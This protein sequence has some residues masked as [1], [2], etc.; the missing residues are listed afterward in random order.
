MSSPSVMNRLRT[1]WAGIQT[2][3]DRYIQAMTMRA[4]GLVAAALTALFSLLEFVEQL[5][6][7]GQGHYR[8]ADAFSYVLLT[9]PDRLLQVTP[10]SMLLGC[11]LAL[12]ALA[13]N[14]ELIALMGLGISEGRIIGSVLKLAVPITLVMFLIAEFIVPPF[15]QQAQAQRTAALAESDSVRSDNSFW[16]QGDHQYLNVQRFDKTDTATGIDIYDF[17]DDGSLDSFVH[18]DHAKIGS[19]GTW[20]LTGVLRKH[21]VESAFETEHLDTLAWHSFMSPDQIR[22]LMLPPQTM[23]PIALYRYV[24]ELEQGHQQAIRYQQEL[25]RKLG[26]P[27]S[28]VAMVMIA[29]PFVFGP[30]R[31]Q[32]TG[33]Q[34]TIGAVFGIVFSLAQQIVGHLDLLLDLNPAATALGPSLVLIGLAVYLFRRAHR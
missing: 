33:Q 4:I 18:A 9:A 6:S 1:A 21:I 14:S 23:P 16:V 25:W 28:M 11:L 3:L 29:A 5:S 7:V 27:L 22:L 24:R 10:V 20:Q 26:I 34:I 12:G 31:S 32:N 30:P 13:K 15:Q 2:P 17:N 8:L 19:D